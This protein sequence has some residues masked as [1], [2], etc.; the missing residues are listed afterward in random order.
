MPLPET[1]SPPKRGFL[2][3]LRTSFLAGLAVIAPIGLTIWLIWTVVGWIDSWVLPL[4]PGAYNPVRLIQDYTG[5]DIRGLGVATFLI[6]TVLVGWIAKGLIGRS[7]ISLAEQLVLTIPGVRTIYSGLKQII[8]TVVSQGER[9]FDKAC[10]V[11]YPRQ[12]IW[13]VAFISTSAKGEIQARTEQDMVSI[14]LPTTPNPTSGFLLFVPREDII[15]LNMTV[16]DAAKLVISAGLVYP[17]P[18]HPAKELR[19]PQAPPA[20]G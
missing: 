12:G 7:M 15:I 3:S 18:A 5:L 6:F 20:T 10:L 16:E 13:A 17:N 8:D 9:S 11:Q 14:F 1:P 4:I 2:A 19:N